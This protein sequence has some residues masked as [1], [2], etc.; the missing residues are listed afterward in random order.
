[1]PSRGNSR[2]DATIRRQRTTTVGNGRSTIQASVLRWTFAEALEPALEAAMDE[3]ERIATGARGCE[4]RH[5]RGAHARCACTC[6]AHQV[7]EQHRHQRERQHQARQQRQRSPTA[8]AARTDIWPSLSAGTPAR[9]RC[10]SRASTEASER[11][12][13]RRRRGSPRSDRL[14]QPDMPLDV[15]DHDGGV[16]DQDADRQRKAAQASWC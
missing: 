14:A 10:R 11:R 15:L 3:A 4:R 16:V 1:M 6:D 2:Q 8:T 5:A 12:P 13:P 7:F 9:T